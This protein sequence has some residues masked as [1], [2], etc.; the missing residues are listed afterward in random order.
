MSALSNCPQCGADLEGGKRSCANCGWTLRAWR[1]ELAKQQAAHDP[2]R[3]QCA[4]TADGLRCRY[5]G[6]VNRGTTGGGDWYCRWHIDCASSVD[7]VRL[8]HQ[9][10]AYQPEEPTAGDDPEI[11]MS[12]KRYGLERRAGE[13]ITEHIHRMRAFCREKVTRFLDQ[14]TH[15]TLTKEKT[16]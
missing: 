5:P 16:S 10:Q 13:S 14:H 2:Q 11:A 4:A 15:N 3:Y 12:L 6:S 1:A 9:S 8:V 7:A